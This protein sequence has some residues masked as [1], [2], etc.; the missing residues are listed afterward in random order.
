MD[1]QSKYGYQLIE[2]GK[3]AGEV[4]LSDFEPTFNIELKNQ[5]FSI[6]EQEAY[7]RGQTNMENARF[8][9]IASDLNKVQK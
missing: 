3:V 9:K 2:S 7:K 6:L 8:M 4:K 1:K 5:A